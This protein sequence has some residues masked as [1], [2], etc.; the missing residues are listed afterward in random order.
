MPKLSQIWPIRTPRCQLRVLWTLPVVLQMLPC[1]SASGPV[2]GS[3]ATVPGLVRHFSGAPWLV[4]V[5]GDGT[6]KSRP[7]VPTAVG[8]LLLPD[9]LSAQSQEES[10]KSTLRSQN[11]TSA[12]SHLIP[13]S[14][15]EPWSPGTTSVYLR[16]PTWF[17]GGCA[18]LPTLP[19]PARSS[20]GFLRRPAA[21]RQ[22][23][24]V[25]GQGTEFPGPLNGLFSPWPWPCSNK[26]RVTQ[27]A[28]GWCCP[29][30][31]VCSPPAQNVGSSCCRASS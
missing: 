19:K 11:L 12:T 28:A 14:P 22:G 16:P 2:P 21:L 24:R 10:R 29:R 31:V 23:P 6:C 9:P 13:F 18:R 26:A 1:F 25:C 8:V 30:V 7:G 5:H 4:P 17:S 27:T 15:C 20:L 3:A